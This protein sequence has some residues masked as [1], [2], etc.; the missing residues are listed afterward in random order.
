[1]KKAVWIK[2]SLH[3]K[4]KLKATN[5]EKSIEEVLEEILEG[6]LEDGTD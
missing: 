1:M 4:L 3:K 2:P 5:D 6:A